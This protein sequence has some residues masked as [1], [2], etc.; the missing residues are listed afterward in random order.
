[1]QWLILSRYEFNGR[2]LKVHYDKFSPSQSSTVPTSPNPQMSFGMS[3]FSGGFN[4]P[5]THIPMPFRYSEYVPS[6]GPSSPY[7]IYPPYVVMQHVTLQDQSQSP[8]MPEPQLSSSESQDL[9][10]SRGANP[11]TPTLQSSQHAN[12]QQNQHQHHP[13][14]IALPPSAMAFPPPHT[15]SPHAISP[16][17]HPM[18]PMHHP[19][20]LMTPHGLPPI[21][22]SMPSF[23]FL[24]QP[25]PSMHGP[26]HQTN[27][28]TP[29][30]EGVPGAVPGHM[31]T[32]YAP[33]SPGLTMSPGAFWGR[34]GPGVNPYAAV[35]A[36]VHL[37]H[38]P[39]GMHPVAGSPV[40]YR[41]EPGGYFPP[42]PPQDYFPFVPPSSSLSNEIMP[43]HYVGSGGSSKDN[44]PGSDSLTA[45]QQS[46]EEEDGEIEIVTGSMDSFRLN[47]NPPAPQPQAAPSR[48]KISRGNSTLEFDG[49]GN[50]H[51]VTPATSTNGSGVLHRSG[52]DPVQTLLDMPGQTN[53]SPHSAGEQQRRASFAE[54]VTEGS[55]P[56]QRKAIAAGLGMRLPSS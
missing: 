48:P 1:M 42:V 37:Q 41:E 4:G 8:R 15:L 34:P 5:P 49:S 27:P 32:T 26:Q 43:D 53:Q 40:G 2:P 45:Y 23:T 6:S 46:S 28:P 30:Y 52:S 14:R 55:S 17:H 22:P 12:S 9:N 31:M 3:P 35:G 51:R 11:P 36:P 25:S 50:Q 20:V 13:G 44:T 33:F 10:S 29:G 24:P 47:G 54:V 21:T 38:T 39:Y 7:D 56:V 16:L 19:H 18:S